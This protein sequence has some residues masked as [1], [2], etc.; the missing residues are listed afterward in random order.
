LNH[1]PGLTPSILADLCHHVFPDREHQ[2]GHDIQT[3]LSRQHEMVAF[4]LV[5][6]NDSVVQHEPLIVRRYVSTISW[7]RADDLGKAQ[8]EVT[9]TKW[10]SEQGFPV[11]KAYGRE[12]NALGDLVVFSRVPGADWSQSGMPFREVIEFLVVPFAQLLAKLHS[13][14]MSD[15]VRTVTPVVTLP[16]ALANLNALAVRMK[17]HGLMGMA[18]RIMKLAF[19]V[20]ET[21]P[22]LLH[23]DYHFSNALLHEGRIAGIVDWEY[24]ALGDPRWDV[25]S[26]YMQ[27]VDFAAANAADTFLQAYLEAS[28]R[29][30]EG[31]PLYNVVSSLQQWAISEWLV[32]A[33]ES[34]ESHTFSLAHDLIALRDV[35]KNRA[36][37]AMRALEG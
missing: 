33:E 4:D 36:E 6:E 32:R 25:S 20:P 13:Y 9:I 10:L 3:L 30:F 23:G 11:P 27:L 31:P 15:D 22:V 24:A 35:H 19:E 26:A 37:L 28:G 8:R 17:H 34:G 16:I 2:H 7:W 12:F 18:E 1:Q 5:W 29:Q 14:P 21:D